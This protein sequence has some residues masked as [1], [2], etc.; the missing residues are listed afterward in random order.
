MDDFE[1][2][3]G[4]IPEVSALLFGD[5]WKIQSHCPHVTEIRVSNC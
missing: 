4:G 3:Y 1:T 5:S 2:P